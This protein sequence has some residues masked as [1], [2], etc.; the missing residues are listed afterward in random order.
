MNPG[1]RLVVLVA[2][3]LASVA[4]ARARPP[5]TAVQAPAITERPPAEA[6]KPFTA[7]ARPAVEAATP[8]EAAKPSAE[9]VTPPAE[10]ARPATE[11]AKPEGGTDAATPNPVDLAAKVEGVY[12]EDMAFCATVARQTAKSLDLPIFHEILQTTWIQIDAQ[13]REAE[14]VL[15]RLEWASN[16]ETRVIFA[17]GSSPSAEY[18]V[19]VGRMKAEFERLLALANR[20]AVEG[21]PEGPAPSP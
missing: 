13:Y 20:P 1:I 7:P 17:A 8:I 11:A 9:S 21:E 6:D 4:C 14:P 18:E 19:L 10:A 12:S 15:F 16:R 3:V 5:K 2:A